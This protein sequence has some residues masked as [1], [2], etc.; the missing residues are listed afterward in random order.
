MVAG[1]VASFAPGDPRRR[2]RAGQGGPGHR[3]TCHREHAHPGGMPAGDGVVDRR[4]DQLLHIGGDFPPTAVRSVPISL[5]RITDS[6]IASTSI[7]SASA[8]VPAGPPSAQGCSSAGP[9]ASES[10]RSPSSC[11]RPRS[12][13]TRPPPL[14][15]RVAFVASPAQTSSID[16]RARRPLHL[17]QSGLSTLLNSYRRWSTD[18]RAY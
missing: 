18:G 15:S 1:V 12:A 14:A 6:S 17:S 3:T 2:W 13:S 7:A 4:E 5:P 9:S 10:A 11:E 8:P 16:D